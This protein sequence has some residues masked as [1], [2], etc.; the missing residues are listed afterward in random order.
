M[1]GL[2]RGRRVA[3]PA[4]SIEKTRRGGYHPPAKASPRTLSY[5]VSFFN[6]RDVASAVPYQFCRQSTVGAGRPR[7]AAHRSV[8]PE[9]TKRVFLCVAGLFLSGFGNVFSIKA[10]EVGTNA[11]NTLAMGISETAAVS[12]GTATALISC[13]IVVID[14]VGRGKLGFGT[15]LNFILIP[16]FSDLC[17]AWFDFVPA[18]PNMIWG[19]VYTLC[20]QLWLS[21]ALVLYMKPA[22]GCGPRDTLMVILGRKMPKAPIGLV[23]F[24][25]EAA[26]LAVGAL[27]G[28]PFGLGSV[29]VLVLQ[30][31]MFQFACF[32]CRYEPRA[33]EHENFLDTVKRWKKR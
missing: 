12:F 10:G 22:L 4:H 2:F 24:L 23:K 32:V 7:R 33:V 13:V 26:A 18:A 8:L 3:A 28:A 19:M 15:L 1:R 6:R 16:V 21:F 29:L 31:S 17:L 27:L 25:L 20:T 9:Y 30:A 14:I 5:S 11:W